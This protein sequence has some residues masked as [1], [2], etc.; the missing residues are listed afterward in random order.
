MNKPVEWWSKIYFSDESKFNLFRN[1]EINWVRCIKGEKFREKCS[2]KT[3]KFGG[4]SV[5]VFDMSSAQGTTPLVHLNSRVNATV[6]K[7]LLDEHV[8][9]N[10]DNSRLADPIFMQDNAPCH[11]AKSVLNYLQEQNVE[12]LD[13][14]PQTPDLNSI[15]SLW[16]T[17]GE[18]VMARD[19]TNTEDL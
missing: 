14:P 3:V 16:K 10:F 13:W 2:K 8:L 11:N 19:P 7:N 5:M 18:N 17:L 15:E 6:Y 12:L 4:G 1:D 9:P